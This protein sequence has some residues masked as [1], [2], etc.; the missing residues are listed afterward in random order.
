[1][2]AS[3]TIASVR[4]IFN[5]GNHNA[6]TDL[7][8]FQDRLY[9]T[10][11]SCP[12]GHML[13]T[14]SSIVVMVSDDGSE[15]KKAF[16]FSVPNRDVRDPHFLIFNDKLFVYSGTWWVDTTDAHERDVN[17]HLGYCIWS[18]DGGTWHGPQMLDGTHGHYIWRA[19]AHDG[20]AYLNGRRIRNFDVVPRRA[21]PAEHMESWLLHSAGGFSWAPLGL[22]QPSYGDETAVLFEEDG[23]ILALARAGG[24]PAQLCRSRPPY[25]DWTRTD[26]DRHVGGPLLA[27]WG[28]FYL[29]GGRKQIDD[30]KPVTALY[31]LIDDALVEVAELPSGGDNSYPGFLELSPESG[32]LS[33]YSSHEG[34]GTSLAPSA[35]YLAELALTDL[36]LTKPASTEVA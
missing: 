22:M 15:W 13:F 5:D 31:W 26:L 21:E 32:L 36:P 29:V 6:F 30:A 27:K 23:S 34:S 9:L 1:M 24:R 4:Q 7:C 11:R 20:M 8:R 16:T 28:T 3:M 18:E 33:Y 25:T 17:H 10:F 35:I 2:T 14:S 19:A 12:D